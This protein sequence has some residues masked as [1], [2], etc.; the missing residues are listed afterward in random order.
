MFVIGH[1]ACI[2]FYGSVLQADAVFDNI[3]VVTGRPAILI[4]SSL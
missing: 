1:N 4:F 3:M 2:S